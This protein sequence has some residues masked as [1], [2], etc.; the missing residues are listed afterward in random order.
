MG[1]F[2]YWFIFIS[3]H[4]IKGKN[5]RYLSISSEFRENKVPFGRYFIEND[6]SDKIS[7]QNGKLIP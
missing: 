6:P 3:N 2:V 1:L 4:K 5:G 7:E